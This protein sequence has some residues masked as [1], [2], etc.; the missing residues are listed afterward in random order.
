MAIIS[1]PECGR[2]VSDKALKCPQCAHPIANPETRDLLLPPKPLQK[3]PESIAAIMQEW[4][5]QKWLKLLGIS[6]AGTIVFIT[7][8]VLLGKGIEASREASRKKELIEEQ[9]QL[10]EEVSKPT[11]SVNPSTNSP[12]TRSPEYLLAGIDKQSKDRQFIRSNQ[13]NIF[14]TLTFDIDN[15]AIVDNTI[16]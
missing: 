11:Y 8:S 1:C 9:K 12:S 10:K 15:L 2:Q 14:T 16:K 3:E 7:S 5:T 4:S 6:V 13:S